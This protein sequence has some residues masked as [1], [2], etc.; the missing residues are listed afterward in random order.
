[1]MKNARIWCALLLTAFGLHGALSTRAD[2]PENLNLD[3][4]PV[5][6]L[7]QTT[8]GH[9]AVQALGNKLPDVAR[10]YGLTPDELRQ[11]LIHDHHLRLDR[12]GRL[13]VED[14]FTV[15]MGAEME[16]DTPVIGEAAIPL[17]DTFKLNSRPGA[18]RTIYL[19][20]DGH[21]LSGTAWNANYNNNQDIVCPPYSFEGSSNTFSTNELLRIQEVWR[22]VAED[23]APFDVNVTTEFPGEDAITRS[24]SSDTRYGMRVLISP[25]SSFFGNYGGIAYVGVFNRVGDYYKPA[26]VFPEKLGN[27]AKYIAEAC[28]HE[29]GHTLGLH[30]DGTT[31]GTTYY[32]GHGTGETGWAP[33]MGNSYSK[34]LTQWSRGEY[35]GANQTQDDFLVMQSFGLPLRHDDHGDDNPSASYL[36]AGSFVHAT[37]LIERQ[38]DVDV[39]AFST[40]AGQVAFQILPAET[41]PNLDISAS[42]YEAS[43]QHILTSNPPDQ[44]A[45]AFDINLSAGTYFLHVSATGKGAPTTGYSDYGSRGQYTV[46]GN[47]SVP[48]GNIAPVAVASASPVTG[49]VPLPVQFDASGSF[50][51]DGQIVSYAWNF[52]DGAAGTGVNPSHTYTFAG[53]YT[54]TLTVTDN[55][56]LT[57]TATVSIHV[58]S[59]N[60]APV[61]VANASP[62]I[63]YAPLPVNFNA[64]GSYDPDGSIVA[65][66]WALG[67]GATASGPTAQHIYPTPGTYTAVLTVTDN[68]GAT[69]TRGILIQVEPNPDMIIRVAAIEVMA[70]EVKGGKRMRALV[71]VTDLQGNPVAGAT[72]TGQWTGRVSGSPSAVT[73]ADGVAQLISNKTNKAG[74]VTFTVTGVSAGGYVYD[75]SQNL[76]T[77]VETRTGRIKR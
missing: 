55:L 66:H 73:N 35:T 64:T 20:F 72:V 70:V 6:N 4:M 7:G 53:N 23:F 69:A 33:I 26:L 60:Q 29:A 45:A 63:G 21:V 42:L 30:H 24:T 19:D 77:S 36:P 62:T 47:I 12:K 34:N 56:G 49:L 58:Q 15:P 9:A 61:A 67:T 51:V 27:N 57:G 46:I 41:G 71:T 22:R 38:G 18:D 48:P 52:G 8:R 44:L 31:S 59:S 11:K 40:G 76:V 28:S 75:P 3:R 13:F 68:S 2:P 1:M 32:A 54:A 14:E 50:D 39:F 43:G 25:I 37:G 65:W 10:A 17:A 5:L 74:P 16:S